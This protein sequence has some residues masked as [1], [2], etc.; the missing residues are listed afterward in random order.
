MHDAGG[1]MAVLGSGFWVSV[2]SKTDEKSH[3]EVS[4]L[5]ILFVID[6]RCERRNDFNYGCSAVLRYCS[7]I[8]NLMC[9]GYH[10]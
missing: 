6:R 9:R 2:R 7:A 10:N 3:G 8:Y 1:L 5:L 4:G